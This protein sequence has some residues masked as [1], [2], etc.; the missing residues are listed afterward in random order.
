MQHVLPGSP[1][2]DL[3]V[4]VS[5]LTPICIVAYIADSS[6]LPMRQKE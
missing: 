5:E 3:G 6:L 1:I 2:Q 4:W